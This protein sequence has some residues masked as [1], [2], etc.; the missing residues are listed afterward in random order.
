MS[1]E[2]CSDLCLSLSLHTIILCID[3][4]KFGSLG[5]NYSETKEVIGIL[6]L[7]SPGVGKHKF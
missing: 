1:P 2:S 7:R 3:V 6:C 5:N 4:D